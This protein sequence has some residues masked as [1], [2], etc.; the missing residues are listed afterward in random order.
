MNMYTNTV[1]VLKKHKL[2]KPTFVATE[3]PS[4]NYNLKT[5]TFW[6]IVYIFQL[7]PGCIFPEHGMRYPPQVLSNSI[8]TVH[9]FLSSTYLP[10]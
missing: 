6:I 9:L 4:W 5:A 8:D 1:S 2:H 7:S 3:N 10:A